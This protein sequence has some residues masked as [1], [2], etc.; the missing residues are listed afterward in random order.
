MVR[1]DKQIQDFLNELEF[2]LKDAILPYW[3]DRM[4]DNEQGGF[5]GQIN[6]HD[7][8]QTGSPKGSV[9]NARILWTFSAAYN[10]YKDQE[11]L[12]MADRAFEYCSQYFMNRMNKGVYWMLDY[13]G[14]PVETKNQIYALGFMM[15]GMSEYYIAARNPVA[16]DFSKMLFR[17]I[18]KHSFDPLESGYYEAFDEDWQLLDDLRLSDKDANEK[19]TM[20]THLHIL[21]GYTNL[22]RIWKNDTLKG[23]LRRLVRVFIEK[24]IDPD[25]HHF[26]LFFDTDWRPKDDEN[27]FGHDIEG[28]WLINE[29]AEVINDKNLISQARQLALDMTDAVIAKGFDQDGALFY[30]LK[31]GNILDSDKHWWPQAEAMVGLVNA[32]EISHKRIYL[33]QALHVWQFVKDKIIDKV[34]GE[35]YF[36]VDRA[37]IPYKEEDKAGIWK[38]PYHNSRACLEILKRLG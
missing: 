25:T 16:L 18:E 20:N 5:Y 4:V 1:T 3:M 9:L 35:W 29:A 32:F 24:I 15:Y 6:G 19:K 12:K 28:S 13:K 33:D 17:S 11:Y 23:Q 38:C 34:G 27:S 21:E 10:H 26:R 2:E 22:Y 30:E 31:P 7:Q 14:R 36:R 37:G 8:L